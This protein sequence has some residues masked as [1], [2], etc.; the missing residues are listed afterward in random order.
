MGRC[1]IKMTPTNREELSWIQ[2]VIIGIA[3]SMGEDDMARRDVLR[4][5]ARVIE[6]MLHDDEEEDHETQTD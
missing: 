3:A 6:S 1:D 2:G 4:S 5:V